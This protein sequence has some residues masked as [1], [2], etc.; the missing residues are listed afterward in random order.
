MRGLGKER[1][2]HSHHQNSAKTTQSSIRNDGRMDLVLGRG[3]SHGV[4]SNVVCVKQ[5]P[6][7]G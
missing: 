1:C 2:G 5:L 4:L 3:G 6:W 7:P